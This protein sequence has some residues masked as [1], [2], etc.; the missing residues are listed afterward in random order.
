[1]VTAL[2]RRVLPSAAAVPDGDKT[3]PPAP[4]AYVAGNTGERLTVIVTVLLDGDATGNT[5][6]IAGF[7][8]VISG[9][10]GSSQVITSALAGAPEVK[11]SRQVMTARKRLYWIVRWWAK[12]LILHSKIQMVMDKVIVHFGNAKLSISVD[13]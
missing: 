10:D 13:E 1:M 11:A 5:P 4:N 7:G 12:K 2:T 9:A 8:V 6:D 3:T